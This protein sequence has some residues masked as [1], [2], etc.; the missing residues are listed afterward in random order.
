MHL[1]QRLLCLTAACLLAAGCTP[2]RIPEKAFPVKG[3]VMLDGNPLPDGTITFSIVAQ[4][5]VVSLPIKDGKFEGQATAGK[6]R[7]EIRAFRADAANDMYKGTAMEGSMKTNFLPAKYNTESTLT[8]EIKTE[9]TT[10]LKFEVT[11][12]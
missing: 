4:G 7:V 6:Q 9:G 5:S 12:Q 3:T 8:A 1:S 2:A 11:S 10:E